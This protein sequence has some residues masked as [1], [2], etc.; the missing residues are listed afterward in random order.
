MK[1]NWDTIRDVLIEVEGLTE[2]QRNSFVYST[3]GDQQPEA[4]AKGEHALLLWKS[5][6]LEGM[7][8]GGLDSPSIIAPELTWSGHDLLK[9]LASEGNWERIKGVAKEKGIELTFDA[10]KALSKYVLDS[11]LGGP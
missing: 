2:T 7:N 11:M 5:G 4:L 3:A 6:Y 1:R 10:V 8:C 9:T